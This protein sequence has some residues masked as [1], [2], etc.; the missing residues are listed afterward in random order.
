LQRGRRL[1]QVGSTKVCTV[2]CPPDCP[3]GTYCSL[4]QGDA[5]CIPDKDQQ[6][7]KCNS[8][9][10]CAMP[11]DGCFKAP[12]GDTFCARDCTVTGLCPDGFTCMEGVVYQGGG[13]APDG[14]APDSGADGGPKPPSGVPSKWCVPSSGASCPCNEKRDGISHTCVN[15]NALRRCVGKETCDGKEG[16]WGACTAHDATEESCNNKDDNCNGHGRR[17]RRQRDVRRVRTQAPARQLDV[18]HGRVQDGQMRPGLV[19]LP[20]GPALAQAARARSRWASRT[21]PATRS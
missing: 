16:K 19:G 10:D 7:A 2:P 21:A 12:A 3:A 4:I 8:A 5:L 15:K 14:G 18:R 13:E 9:A 20:A 17:R 6:C 1:H 11:T